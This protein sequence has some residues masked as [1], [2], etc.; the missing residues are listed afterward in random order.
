[1]KFPGLQ[2]LSS[3]VQ[4]QHLEIGV[5]RVSELGSRKHCLNSSHPPWAEVLEG[6][7]PGAEAALPRPEKVH[8]LHR[9]VQLHEQQGPGT[10][11]WGRVSRGRK[12]LQADFKVC[13]FGFLACSKECEWLY[14]TSDLA[15]PNGCHALMV[16]KIDLCE[17]RTPSRCG[18][19]SRR[20]GSR[21]RS[22]VR[23]S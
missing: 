1:M 6:A 15:S 17:P 12:T 9:Q 20:R 23:T 2:E 16:V 19:C 13:L 4:F 21:S 14:C 10:L 22:A 18:L 3:F 11:A 8:L 7:D 5:V